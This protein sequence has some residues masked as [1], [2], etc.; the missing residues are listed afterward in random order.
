MLELIKESNKIKIILVLLVIND[1]LYLKKLPL[2]S[3]LF[4]LKFKRK[5]PSKIIEPL[6]KEV[7]ILPAL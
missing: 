4:L 5:W 2:N 7:I 1:S 3:Y 6:K